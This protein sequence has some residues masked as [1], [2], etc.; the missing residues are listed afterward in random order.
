MV[1]DGRRQKLESSLA[2]EVAGILQTELKSPLPG[3]VTITGVVLSR[4]AGEVKF[5]YTVLGS[6]EDRSAVARRL[7][8]LAS[9]IQREVS[10]RLKLR[11]TPHVRF[12][13]DDRVNKG[14]RVLE[15]LSRLEKEDG[16]DSGNPS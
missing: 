16:A 7:T 1:A 4:D 15:L 5:H 11:V 10:H 3:L 14:S 13:F 9:F 6:D 12:E 8:Q 2:R